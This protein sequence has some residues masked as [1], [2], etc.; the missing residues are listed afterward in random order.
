MRQTSRNCTDLRHLHLQ[1]GGTTT[2]TVNSVDWDYIAKTIAKKGIGSGG[3]VQRLAIMM[4]IFGNNNQIVE[5]IPSKDRSQYSQTRYQFLLTAPFNVSNICCNIFKK[6]ISH[7]YCRKNNMHPILATMASES[8]LRTQKWLEN[9]CNGFD[10][11]EPVS[12]PMSFWCDNDVLQY[13]KEHNLKLASVYGDVVEDYRSQNQVTG[14]ISL[15]DMGL[16]DKKPIY[17]TSGCLRTGCIGCGFG[18]Q[19]EHRPNRLE[20]IDKVSNPKL[21][22]FILR[23][24]SFD[25]DGLWKPDDRGLGF[26]F[27]YLYLNQVGNMKIYIPEIERYIKEYGT[28]QTEIYLKCPFGKAK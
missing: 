12:N 7:A 16:F 24:G 13:I 2:S 18:L 5:N 3:S 11:K 9:G 19:R 20:M 1:G 26:W 8:R 6:N 25:E 21:R 27:V 14:Q 22:D 17:T 15:A 23:G 10:L 4:G 28:E